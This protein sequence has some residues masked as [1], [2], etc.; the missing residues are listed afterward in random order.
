MKVVKLKNGVIIQLHT[1]CTLDT[2]YKIWLFNDTHKN[3][4][5]IPQENIDFYFN[6]DEKALK[7][8]EHTLWRNKND[9]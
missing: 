4:W 8:Y 1:D 9:V 5:L 6:G 2:S 7:Q 3:E